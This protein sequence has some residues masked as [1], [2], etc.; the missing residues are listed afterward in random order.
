MFGLDWGK[1]QV[2]E[3]P[4]DGRIPPEDIQVENIVG[5]VQQT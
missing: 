3:V 5:I 2:G 1:Y 4:K